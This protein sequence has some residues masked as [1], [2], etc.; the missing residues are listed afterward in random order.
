MFFLICKKTKHSRLKQKLL[1]IISVILLSVILFETRA[2]PFTAKCVAK[3]SKA[4]SAKII[5]ESVTQVQKE[6]NFKYSDL[7][8]ISTSDS[9]EVRF[10][11]ANAMNINKLKSEVALRIQ[12]KLDREGMYSFKLP[13]GAFFDVTTL[14]TLGPGVEVSFA[15]TGSVNCRLKSS[16]ESAGVNQTIHHILLVVSTDI[17]A[18]GTEFK[19]HTEFETEFEIAQTV[20]VGNIP[21]TFADIVR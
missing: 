18:L 10:I 12:N 19:E 9:G 3:Q 17:I 7:A 5:S 14:S 1:I 11:S 15:L 16:F 2:I 20:I 21:S 4:I 6:L 8:D 13:L